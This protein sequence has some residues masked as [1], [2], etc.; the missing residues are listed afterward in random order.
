MNKLKNWIG[1]KL[2]EFLG[3]HD[4]NNAIEYFARNTNRELNGIRRDVNTHSNKI[5]AI[6]TTLESVVH[7]GTDIDTRPYPNHSWAVV[8]IEG[9]VNMIK[10]VNLN[11]RDARGVMDFLKQFEAGRHCIDTPNRYFMDNLIFNIDNK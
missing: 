2:S 1:L 10:F 11:N 6:Y 3:I 5:D 4:I 7:I 8:C 9:R